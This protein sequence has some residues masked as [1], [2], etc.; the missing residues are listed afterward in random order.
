M[1]P[2][3]S[4]VPPSLRAVAAR[5]VD[6]PAA[7]PVSSPRNGGE[8]KRLN[9]AE[10]ALMSVVFGVAALLYLTGSTLGE[11]VQMVAAVG[12]LGAVIVASATGRI[13]PLVWI[14]KLGKLAG[15]E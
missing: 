2:E 14:G 1:S 8:S 12:G 13:R 10:A 11:V 4:P 7:V 5:A 9:A 6:V 15:E 3:D